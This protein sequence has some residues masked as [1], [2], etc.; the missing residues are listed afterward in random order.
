[1]ALS[2]ADVFVD[3]NR[4]CVDRKYRCPEKTNIEAAKMS[5]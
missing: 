1:V 4:Y 5:Y 3:H 2:I